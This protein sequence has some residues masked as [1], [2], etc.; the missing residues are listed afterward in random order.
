MFNYSEDHYNP[1]SYSRMWLRIDFSISFDLN[2]SVDALMRDG[3]AL[4][5]NNKNVIPIQCPN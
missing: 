3:I 4:D 1:N 2:D 5:K